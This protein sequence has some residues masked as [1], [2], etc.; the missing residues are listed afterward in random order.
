MDSVNILKKQFGVICDNKKQADWVLK[1]LNRAKQNELAIS[2]YGENRDGEL[3]KFYPKV[4]ADQILNQVKCINYTGNEN[5]TYI[6][7]NGVY[8]KDRT[9][10]E[11]IN[12]KIIMED[13]NPDHHRELTLKEIRENSMIDVKLLNN[14]KNII[15]FK[16]GIYDINE[17]A[18][19]SH[20][21]DIISTIQVQANY[22]ADAYKHL[23]NTL[24]DH[25]LK[26]SLTNET[27]VLLQEIF[28]YCLTTR[29]DAQKMF[30]FLGK[31]ANGKTQLMNILAALFIDDLRS[32]LELKHFQD[33]VRIFSLLGKVL[34]ICSDISSEYIQD[35]SIIKKATGEDFIECNPKYRDPIR[36]KCMAKILF[37]I[38]EMP[39]VA[40][41]S[42]GY[43]RRNIIIPFDKQIPEN[44]RISGIS[45]KIINDKKCMDAI[46]SWGV[47]GLKRLMKNNWKFSESGRIIEIK[48]EYE[49]ENNNLKRFIN[50]YC[51]IK[52]SGD[53]IPVTEFKNLYKKWCEREDCTRLRDK[54]LKPILANYAEKAKNTLFK[55]WYYEGIA[56]NEDIADL[57]EPHYLNGIIKNNNSNLP[58]LDSTEQD[59]NKKNETQN[60]NIKTLT[61]G[62]SGGAT[63][64][65]GKIDLNTDNPNEIKGKVFVDDDGNVYIPDFTNDYVH[66]EAINNLRQLRRKTYFKEYKSYKDQVFEMFQIPI[67]IQE[68]VNI[69][70]K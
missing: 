53:Y 60:K 61:F 16:N 42:Y 68:N 67:D 25:L 63:P 21:S 45:E 31:G 28:G 14:N 62:N 36:F 44:Q 38:N 65:T 10:R 7:K 1:Q 30:M 13:N 12:N 52:S 33:D 23:E 51:V 48:N 22:I 64:R 47:I 40:D 18:L 41:K 57:E 46:T 70:N 15:N 3:T 27:I 11:M 6:Y 8:L 4:L 19:T 39:N 2:V 37:A 29:L 9:I 35:D 26:T 24:F 49:L 20:S 32:A 17:D 58:L 43:M 54:K 66:Q 50:E 59:E 69:K 55:G 56:W 34:N 5:D